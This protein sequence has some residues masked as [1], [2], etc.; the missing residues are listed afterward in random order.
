ML[1]SYIP[2]IT[3]P[4]NL[5]DKVPK[6]LGGLLNSDSID[7]NDSEHTFCGND[8]SDRAELRLKEMSEL[9]LVKHGNTGLTI[10]EGAA[11][12]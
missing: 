1:S 4:L 7:T 2:G 12:S 5:K 3:G 8:A 10:A 6:F 9:G 11:C